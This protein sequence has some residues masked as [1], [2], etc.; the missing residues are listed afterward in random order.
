ML[1]HKHLPAVLGCL[2][3]I[4]GFPASM[5]KRRIVSVEIFTVHVILCYTERFTEMINLS[6]HGFTSL[7]RYSSENT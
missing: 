1:D 4:A 6:N 3:F 7:D 5:I 2:I